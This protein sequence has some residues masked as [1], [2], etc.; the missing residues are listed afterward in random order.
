MSMY[1][2]DGR[3]RRT[4][5]FGSYIQ[6]SVRSYNL[7]EGQERTGNVGVRAPNEHRLH[8]GKFGRQFMHRDPAIPPRCGNYTLGQQ[9]DPDARGHTAQNR[10]D[11]TEFQ[12]LC[13]E[14]SSPVQEIVQPCSIRATNTKDDGFQFGYRG[15]IFNAAN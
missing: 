15:K 13:S 9:G 2:L 14:Y 7:K 6:F 5:L 8:F 12:G 4:R 1:W 11:R 3:L 10:F